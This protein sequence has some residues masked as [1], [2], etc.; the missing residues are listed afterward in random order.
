MVVDKQ[1]E[2]LAFLGDASQH[3]AAATVERIDTHASFVFLAGDRAYKLKR[4][5]RYDYLDYSTV[6][7]R[8]EAC[9]AEVGLNRRTAPDL[10]LGTTPVTRRADGTPQFGGEGKPLDWLVVMRRFPQDQLLDRIAAAGTLASEVMI[11]LA[12][13]VAD[14]HR[15]ADPRRESGGAA[16][17][18]RVIEG[19]AMALIASGD[20]LD[21]VAVTGLN[22]NLGALVANLAQTLDAR[23]AR[24]MVRQCHGD[25]H[26]RNIVMLN[27]RPTL[28]DAVEFSED[29]ACIDVMYDFAFLVMDL[30]GRD[31]GAHANA[32]LNRYLF[33]TC[34]FEGLRLLPLFLACRATIRAKTSLAAAALDQNLTRV[35]QLR[36]R[37]TRYLTLATRVSECQPPRL[38][39][40]GGFSG[41]GK[42]T[43]AMRLAPAI[44]TLPG[45]VVLRSDVVRKQVFGRGATQPLPPWA[46][47]PARR[48]TVYTEMRRET[49]RAIQAG[50][51]VVL[52]AV[53]ADDEE[54][55]ATED[56]AARA[57][58]SFI[59]LWLDADVQT[60]EQRLLRRHGDASD[61]TVD[62][63][64]R[65]LQQPTRPV[66]WRRIDANQPE[67]TMARGAQRVLGL[68]EGDRTPAKL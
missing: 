64:H 33:R 14:F 5:V 16:G 51:S 22:H 9:E 2:V 3:S 65:Q 59:G 68:T 32:L 1:V 56:L 44:G 58:V 12:D 13:I 54:R 11:E 4:A 63:L 42:S 53:F 36:G 48:H 18:R 8:R 40:I 45:A 60:L 30:L 41:S 15:Q 28:F 35:A 61:A 52:D 62:V 55:R 29:F 19:N 34:D 7:R 43:L 38:V 6:E 25:L 17:I 49:A 10:Y 46:Y 57:G 27:G 24:G 67:E 47:E 31:L 26:L 50:Y 20:A 23:R 37:A 66:T 39:A 21:Q